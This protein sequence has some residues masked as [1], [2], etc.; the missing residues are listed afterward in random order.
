M[1]DVGQGTFPITINAVEVIPG[2][3]IGA[4]NVSH[5]FVRNRNGTGIVPI[6]DPGAGNVFF[7]SQGQGT[8]AIS[9]NSLGALTGFSVDANNVQHGFLRTR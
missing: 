7:L 9:I 2:Q 6:D 8:L 3:I 1:R 5:G 4:N